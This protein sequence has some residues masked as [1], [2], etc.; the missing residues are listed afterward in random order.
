MEWYLIP[1]EDCLS[2]TNVNVCF[3]G[4]HSML[5]V[6]V[7]M[8]IHVLVHVPRW[9]LCLPLNPLPTAVASGD[10]DKSDVSPLRSLPTRSRA[11]ALNKR[12]KGECMCVCV[13]VCV[14]VCVYVGGG[15][16]FVAC[17]PV[18]ISVHVPR[19]FLRIPFLQLLPVEMAIRVMCLLY[20]HYQPVAEHRL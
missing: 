18:S 20:T 17:C 11:Q 7:C 4:V 5:H 19:W 15:G 3:C 14:C 8:Y 1:E 12:V 2:Q 10:G 16:M 13:S 9:F 6:H